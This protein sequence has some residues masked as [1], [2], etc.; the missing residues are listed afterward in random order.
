MN[1]LTSRKAVV[2]GDF[3]G[4]EARNR[5]SVS[6]GRGFELCFGQEQA[7]KCTFENINAERRHAVAS[8]AERLRR[9]LR[10]HAILV[11]G[12]VHA[13]DQA[14]LGSAGTRRNLLSELKHNRATVFTLFTQAQSGAVDV[15]VHD[16]TDSYDI[17]IT[18]KVV[19]KES[20]FAF[21]PC[22]LKPWPHLHILAQNQPA[23]GRLVL[24]IAPTPVGAGFSSSPQALPEGARV[25]AGRV[26]AASCLGCVSAPHQSALAMVSRD[27]IAAELHCEALAQIDRVSTSALAH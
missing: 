12:E 9:K 7:F 23:K 19:Q 15:A 16:A 27:V 6:C 5:Q 20:A 24:S 2:A 13:G 22:V 4:D 26:Y 17:F 14:L 3:P 21:D 10:Q 18:W 25:R 11:F 8:L 1:Q